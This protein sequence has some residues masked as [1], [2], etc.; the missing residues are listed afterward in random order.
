ME[1]RPDALRCADCKFEEF[2]SS[3][4]TMAI[5]SFLKYLR[6]RSDNVKIFAIFLHI[7]NRPNQILNK[8]KDC[9][10]D[11]LEIETQYVGFNRVICNSDA[12]VLLAQKGIPFPRLP[13]L[14]MLPVMPTITGLN[15][16]DHLQIELRIAVIRHYLCVPHASPVNVLHLFPHCTSSQC[17]LMAA[18]FRQARYRDILD[19]DSPG[20]WR[21]PRPAR[22]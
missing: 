20:P 3:K 11:F 9:L 1:L 21:R 14:H 18:R 13:S 7:V 12:E 2:F 16:I 6:C 5:A 17:S 22:I 8:W 10:Q 19:T 4:R 15:F